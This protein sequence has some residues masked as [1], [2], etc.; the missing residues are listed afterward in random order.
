[1]LT[2]MAF[3]LFGLLLG[4]FIGIGILAVCAIGPQDEWKNDDDE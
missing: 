1:M 2:K 3:L 4:V